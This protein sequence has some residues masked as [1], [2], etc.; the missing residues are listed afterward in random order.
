MGTGT[1]E[2]VHRAL[3]FSV[4]EPETLAWID[5]FEP[6]VFWDVGANV[7]VYS[8]YCAARWPGVE[9]HSFEPDA[10][11]Y[12]ALCRNVHLNDLAIKPY[13]LAI[14]ASSKIVDLYVASL[15][16][17]AGAAAVGQPYLFQKSRGASL[18]QRVMQVSIDDLIAKHS[19]PAPDYLKIDVDGIEEDI[20]EGAV[21][22]L[23]GLKGLLVEFQYR[24]ESD[25][26]AVLNTLDGYGLKLVE[27][28]EW[29][30][31]GGGLLSRNHIFA[32]V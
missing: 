15:N 16:A 17:G 29:I 22:T 26:A 12:A 23:P 11:S 2:E 30:S 31:G 24:E 19:L 14:G 3:N 1:G 4:R 18:I 27:R 6:G 25:L 8:L 20:L 28:S 21:N 10:Q 5:T 32:R 13:G 9:I 7:G